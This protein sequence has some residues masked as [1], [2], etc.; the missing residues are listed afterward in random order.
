MLAGIE[1]FFK[2]K[3]SIIKPTDWGLIKLANVVLLGK[4]LP[5]ATKRTPK[6]TK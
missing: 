5:R 6:G 3:I 2:V 4:Y 1:P